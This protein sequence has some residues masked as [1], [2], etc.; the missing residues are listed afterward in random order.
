[1]AGTAQDLGVSLRCA[2]GRASR[3]VGNETTVANGAESPPR[4][5][6]VPMAGL[7]PGG[8]APPPPGRKSPPPPLAHPGTEVVGCAAYIDAQALAIGCAGAPGCCC[9]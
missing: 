7:S 9:T 8:P 5:E 3:A 6:I 4:P 1:M 2:P